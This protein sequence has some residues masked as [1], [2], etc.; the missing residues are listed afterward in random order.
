M[1]DQSVTGT[2]T[3]PLSGL[4]LLLSAPSKQTVDKAANL[5]FLT[6]HAGKEQCIEAVGGLLGME[7]GEAEQVGKCRG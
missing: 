2:G 1:S 6:R 7:R 3:G 5:T 4:N